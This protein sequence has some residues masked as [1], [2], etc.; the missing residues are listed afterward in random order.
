M[1]TAQLLNYSTTQLCDQFI[2]N[3]AKGF[4]LRLCAGKFFSQVRDVNIYCAR[5]AGKIIAPRNFEQ[6]L[7]GVNDAGILH[8]RCE[9]IKFLGSQLDRLAGN[10]CFA[11][12]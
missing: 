6:A 3:P 7:A 9:Q 1:T 5:F 8:E 11:P 12:R 2:S 10:G 4:D